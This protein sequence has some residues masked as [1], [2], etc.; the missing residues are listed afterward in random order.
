MVS[1]ALALE[2]EGVRAIATTCGLFSVFQTILT[3]VVDIPVLSSALQQVPMVSLLIG[4]Q[5]MVE[6]HPDIG[7]IVLECT[8][9]PPAAMAIQHATGLP[10]FV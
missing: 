9:M 6:A 7:A 2:K 1:A 3:E 5:R 10:V 4:S 8:N